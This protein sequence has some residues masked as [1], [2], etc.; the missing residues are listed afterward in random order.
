MNSRFVWL[1]NLVLILFGGSVM[2]RAGEP[3]QRDIFAVPQPSPR[4]VQQPAAFDP[5]AT[6]EPGVMREEIDFTLPITLTSSSKNLALLNAEVVREQECWND[7]TIADIDLL[8]L[9]V[10]RQGVQLS[11]PVSAATRTIVYEERLTDEE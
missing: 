1:L 3:G 2:A 11:L 4:E 5:Q 6:P 8:S 9:L 7:W 10:A